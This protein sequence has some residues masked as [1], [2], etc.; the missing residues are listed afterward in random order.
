MRLGLDGTPLLGNQTGI[1]LYTRRLMQQLADP[2]RSAERPTEVRATA[3]TLRG[4]D[5]LAGRVPSG[6]TTRAKPVPARLL[7]ASWARWELPPVEWLC[8]RID[9]FHGTNFVLPPTRH[10]HGVVTI[11]DLS[12]LRYPDTV[13]ADSLRYQQLVPRSIARADVVCALSHAMADEI[14][15]EYSVERAAIHVVEPGVDEA[16]FEAKPPDP[17]TKRRLGLPKRYVLAVGTLEPRKNLPLLI[18]AY[19]Q[20]RASSADV[21]GLVLI[22]PAGWG[23]QLDLDSLP[24]GSVTTT[25]YLDEAVLRRVVAGASC[26][27]F[28]S[29]YEGFGIPPVEALACGVPVVATDLPVT[30]EVLGDA[31]RL[32]PRGDC[33]SLAAALAQE[34][35][36]TSTAEEILERQARA[37]R[38]TW[39][40][41]A[42]KAMAAYEAALS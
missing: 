30:R 10:A 19:G 4:R 1:G 29:L 27:A 26:V 37:R 14:A 18:A 9:V 22:G 13:T 20:W 39:E 33:E 38:W 8:G 41:C 6:V 35:A 7:R 16:W 31:A 36:A 42:Q 5:E 11:H 23:P 24:A 12:F 40:A 25:G 2:G 15:A 34:C 28:P 21:P 32:V 3:F 17:E